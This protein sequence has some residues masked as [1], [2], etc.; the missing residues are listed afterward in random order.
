MKELTDFRIQT[1]AWLEAN[2]PVSMHQPV[3]DPFD[4][5]WGG[6]GAT[7]KSEDQKNHI[8]NISNK[9]INTQEKLNNVLSKLLLKIK[10]K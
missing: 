9:F 8:S 2:C 3:K 5:Y 10:Q 7:F 4:L 6:R 1:R